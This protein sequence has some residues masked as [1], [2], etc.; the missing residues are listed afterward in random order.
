[1]KLRLVLA[2]Y[3]ALCTTQALAHDGQTMPT[4]HAPIGVMGDHKHYQGEWM[5][6][7]RYSS[8]FMDGNKD[9]TSGV[10]NAE[11]L[12]QFMATPT[13]MEMNM[14]MFGAMYAPVDSIT[15]MAMLPY[16]SKEMTAVNR[17]GAQFST[18]TEGIG[19]IKLNSLTTLYEED[20]DTLFFNAGL[21]LPTGSIDE[22][23][24]TPMAMNAV[25]PYGMQLGSGTVD[26]TLGLT[27]NYRAHNWAWGAQALSTLRL[28]ENDEDYRLGN[29]YGFTTWASH[30]V[31]DEMSLSARIQA[32]HW[33]NITGADARLN[34]MMTP[35]ARTDMRGGSRV[36]ALFGVNL[37][38]QEGVAAGHRLALEFGI[39]LYEN[40]EGPQ[41]SEDYRFVLGWQKSF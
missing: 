15:L 26:P 9:G 13:E 21:S 36:E 35:G 41:L 11:V 18:K 19:D 31:T 2:A 6:S 32:S 1:M 25:L 33:G 39:P 27:Y 24:N 8:M 23:G 16:V 3:T 14:H 40:L 4:D 29:R 28:Y 12:S 30:N 5:F 22:R 20:N 34:P 37:M 7:Y 10:S 17:M 38:A